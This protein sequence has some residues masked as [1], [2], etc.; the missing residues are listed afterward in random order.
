MN[1]KFRNLLNIIRDFLSTNKKIVLCCL[2]LFLVGIV[3]GIVY[4][5][6][7]NGGEF[8]RVLKDDMTFGA[9]KVFFYSSLLVAI[10]YFAVAISACIRGAS[11][12]S[13]FPFPIL[14]YVFGNYV[15]LLVGCYGGIGIINLIFVY[16][17]FF[18]LTFVILTT[19]TC[20][21]LRLSQSCGCSGKG[22]F[23]RPSVTAVLKGYGVN[24]ICSFV[25]FLLVGG[26]VKVLVV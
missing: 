10:G 19:S 1:T 8:E 17:P 24:I 6:T 15:T 20:I 23:L 18:L 14:G 9:V 5:I 2:I 11:F 13:A 26:I 25:V 12:V 22:A 4:T 16:V 21:A 3:V 7:A